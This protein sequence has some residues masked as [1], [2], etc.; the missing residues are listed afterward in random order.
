MTL[1]LTL[2]RCAAWALLM[3]GWV[4]LGSFAMVLAPSTA[5]AFAWIALWL[6][7]LGAAASLSTR[8]VPAAWQRRAALL[9]CAAIAAAGLAAAPR[10][11]GQPALLLALVAW[12]ALT[13]LASGVVRSLRLRQQATPS[14]PVAT[15]AAGALLAALALDD[16]GDLQG[17]AQ[18]LGALVLLAALGLALLQPA[19]RKAD[20]RR[21]R[22]GLFD[23]SLPA[24]PRGAWGDALQWPTLLAGLA[25]LPMMATLPWM[26]AWCRADGLAPQAVVLLHLGAMFGPALLLQATRAFWSPRRLATACAGC[27]A[28]GAVLLLWTAPP[29]NLL[30][31]AL[32]H[33]AAWGLAWAGQLWA[34]DRR[35][36]A[37]AS[38]WRAALGYALLTLAF[39]SVVAGFGLQGVIGAHAA[40]GLAAALAWLAGIGRHAAAL[41]PAVR[42]GSR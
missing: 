33:G 2:A 40:L 17:L 35:G 9:L 3:A 30:G 6:L 41:P 39:G 27:L 37:G 14:P 34:P 11:G 29:W 16:V 24:W 36:Q 13:A 21:C 32:A 26:V 4:G 19:S 23:C 1:R 18:R 38:P 10:G 12:A 20:A 28:A 25:M 31:L 42:P 5:S 15:A 7:L 22:A 8:E